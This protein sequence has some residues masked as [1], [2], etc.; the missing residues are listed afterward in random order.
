MENEVGEEERTSKGKDCSGGLS[1]ENNCR[2][3]DE[4]L[5][6]GVLAIRNA[7]ASVPLNS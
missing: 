3:T 6:E 4:E 2:V 7:V 5:E 1:T